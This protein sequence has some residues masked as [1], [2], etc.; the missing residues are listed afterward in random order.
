MKTVGHGKD[1]L[2]MAD[3]MVMVII[4]LK[5]IKTIWKAILLMENF[6]GSIK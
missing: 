4:K 3:L 2:K 6:K 5:I 1:K